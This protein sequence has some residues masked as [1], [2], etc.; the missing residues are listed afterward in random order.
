MLRNIKDAKKILWYERLQRRPRSTQTKQAL[1]ETLSIST[2]QASRT[3]FWLK[4][5]Q[6]LTSSSECRGFI[7]HVLLWYASSICIPVSFLYLC[8]AF[9]HLGVRCSL[10]HIFN[11]LSITSFSIHVLTIWVSLLC[12]PALHLIPSVLIFSIL[13]IPIICLNVRVFVLVCLSQLSSVLC[14]IPYII[15]GL[16]TVL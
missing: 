2:K 6:H 9:V 7:L 4:L 15:I 8:M 11:A 16:M 12:T 1:T 3:L 5:V 14:L 13:F 10:T